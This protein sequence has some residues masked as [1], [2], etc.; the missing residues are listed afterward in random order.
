MSDAVLTDRRDGV[1][2]ITLNR[3][4]ARNALTGAMARSIAA[5][6]AEL[7]EDDG[8]HVAILTGAGGHFSAGM[9]LK[10]FVEGEL[11]M[12]EGRGLAGF[13]ER[14]PRKPIIA[15]IEGV[16]VAGGFEI[17]L[18]CDIIVAGRGAR[19]GGCRRSGA[20]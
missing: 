20:G 15:A 7:D 3:P 11:P 4:D 16:A 5:L 12:V 18:C 13:A 17:A 14:P 9:D 6:V 2:T 1:L 8:L 10:A 19:F